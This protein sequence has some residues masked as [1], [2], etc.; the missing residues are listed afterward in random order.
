MLFR[1]KMPRSCTTCLFS[2]KLAEHQLLCS[3]CGVVADSYS[4]RK[5]KYDPCKRIPP[6]VKAPDFQKYNEEDFKLE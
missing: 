4:C 3:R 5:Y 1:R 6:S 2:T